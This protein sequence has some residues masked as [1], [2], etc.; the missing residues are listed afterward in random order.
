MHGM[1]SYFVLKKLPA[2]AK[3]KCFFQ[4][5]HKRWI[6]RPRTMEESMMS[7]DSKRKSRLKK[8]VQIEITTEVTHSEWVEH[9]TNLKADKHAFLTKSVGT[10]KKILTLVKKPGERKI[11]HK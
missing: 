4:S 8:E 2:S 6:R 10:Y 7:L 9:F 1:R 3:K 5:Q 11:P